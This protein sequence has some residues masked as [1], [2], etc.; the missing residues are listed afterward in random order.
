MR[1]TPHTYTHTHTHT[2]IHIYT[3]M[4]TH[5]HTHT[6]AYCRCE[7]VNTS[8]SFFLRR[9]CFFCM[10]TKRLYMYTIACT[11]KMSISIYIYIYIYISIY[12]Y[13]YMFVYV[14]FHAWFSCFL[15][16]PFP[17][18]QSVIRACSGEFVYVKRLFTF[19]YTS[20]ILSFNRP[21]RI[22]FKASV[23]HSVDRP[24]YIPLIDR[25]TFR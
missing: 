19:R 21:L 14:H 25:Y 24:L 7:R 6:C 16:T 1:D 13:I 9:L 11:C 10:Y 20:L 8:F 12:V 18:H 23:T 5:T 4:H 17:R 22:P 3:Q 2:H 15:S